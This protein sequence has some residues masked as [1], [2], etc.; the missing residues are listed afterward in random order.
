GIAAGGIVAVALAALGRG[1]WALVW[2]MNT[3]AL[4]ILLV[5]GAAARWRPQLCFDPA[6]PANL[7]RFSSHFTAA[8]VVNYWLRNLDNL[9]VGAYLGRAALGFYSQAYHMMLYPV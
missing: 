7:W 2:Q 1:V 9:L 6:A 5:T 3:T 4:A 8:S